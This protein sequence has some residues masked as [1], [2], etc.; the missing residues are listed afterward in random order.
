M[1]EVKIALSVEEYEALM[2]RLDQLSARAEFFERA[3][4]Q[5]QDE[6]NKVK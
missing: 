5:Y 6:L 1:S 2:V 4:L 3:A